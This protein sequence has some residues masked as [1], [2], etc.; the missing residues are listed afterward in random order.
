[1]ASLTAAGASGVPPPR[2]LRRNRTAFSLSA[3]TVTSATP[4][5]MGESETASSGVPR[6]TASC[7]IDSISCTG[8]RECS[9]KPSCG[10]TGEHVPGIRRGG[11]RIAREEGEETGR[12]SRGLRERN[13]VVAERHDVAPVLTPAQEPG[14]L[15]L[16][17]AAAACHSL[18]EQEPV[19]FGTGGLDEPA[20]NALSFLPLRAG[21]D[22]RDDAALL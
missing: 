15:G 7:I 12:P 19:V 22:A 2:P 4:L 11:G 5:T 20:E 17:V 18:Q 21:T 14:H 8:R 1:M 3:D 6:R 16:H 13:R 10:G 9:W